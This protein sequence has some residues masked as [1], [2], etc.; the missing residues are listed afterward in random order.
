VATNEDGVEQANMGVAYG[1]YR[2]T[3]RMSLAI[4][5]FDVE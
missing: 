3:G 5:H 1:D 2:H 4:S